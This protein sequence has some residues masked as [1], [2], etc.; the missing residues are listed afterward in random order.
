MTSHMHAVPCRED[1][2][3]DQKAQKGIRAGRSR[4]RIRVY[5]EIG[6][7]KSVLAWRRDAR[8][9]PFSRERRSRR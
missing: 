9:H 5:A 3:P 6:I 4:F 2:A 7:M 1:S 8:C